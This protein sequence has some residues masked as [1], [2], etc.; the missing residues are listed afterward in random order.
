MHDTCTYIDRYRTQRR[1]DAKS[2]D[3]A[4]F[5]I[6][7]IL[8]IWMSKRDGI[9]STGLCRTDVSRISDELEISCRAIKHAVPGRTD[10]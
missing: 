2:G 1:S 5:R 4:G 6:L 7:S 10:V 8:D 9:R 3:D